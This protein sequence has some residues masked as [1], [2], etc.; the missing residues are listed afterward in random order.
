[1]NKVKDAAQAWEANAIAE[2]MKDPDYAAKVHSGEWC[3]ACDMQIPCLCTKRDSIQKM[4]EYYEAHRRIETRGWNGMWKVE[5]EEPKL[6]GS[7][8]VDMD[9]LMTEL[10][11]IATEPYKRAKQS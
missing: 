7:W 5:R 11:R 8:G 2:C 3:A 9:G 4:R 10:H 1:M 6:I